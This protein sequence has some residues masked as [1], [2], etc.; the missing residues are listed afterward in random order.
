MEAA[1]EPDFQIVKKREEEPT[2]KVP[3]IYREYSRGETRH[4]SREHQ[5]LALDAVPRLSAR[6]E[7]NQP[8]TS[9]SR[10]DHVRE[11]GARRSPR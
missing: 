8:P 3:I 7:S 10:L 6:S 11:A 9:S 1:R 2:E 5:G 4:G